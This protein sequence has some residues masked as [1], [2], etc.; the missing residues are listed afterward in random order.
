M[1]PRVSLDMVLDIK[2][3]PY[4]EPN[5]LLIEAIYYVTLFIS[6]QMVSI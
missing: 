3:C 2:F 5:I 1:G 4:W 6:M